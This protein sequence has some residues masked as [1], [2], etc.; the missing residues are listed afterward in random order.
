MEQKDPFPR[1]FATIQE[2]IVS[3]P[4]DNEQPVLIRLS[5]GTYQGPITIDKPYITL[6]G[7]SPE[8]TKITGS[9][10]AFE[11]LEDGIKRGTFRTQTVFID[12]HDFTAKNI[13]FE[14]AA[15]FGRLAGQA[16][17]LYVDGDHIVFDHCHLLASQD[18]LFAAPLPPKEVEPGGFRGPKEFAPR[19]VGR[20]YYKDCYIRGD[21]D[22]IFGGATAYF[23]NCEIF[24]QKTDDAP[25]AASMEEQKIYG[26]VT[27]AST[28]KES[29]YG[30]VFDHCKLTGNCPD[31][32]C[33]LGRPWREFAKVVYLHCEMGAHI[34]PEGWHDWGKTS[35]YDTIFFA[36]YDSTG[37]GANPEKRASFS[38]QLTDEEAA[39]YTIDHI[40]G[41]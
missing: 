31:N 2:A 29:P 16:L 37:P 41:S 14:N 7:D 20:H 9:L 17:A 36:E 5:P 35:A 15:G 32:S 10:G 28:P 33:Y 26:Y 19:I 11:I 18:T 39:E 22:F 34:R 24:S 3:V 21:V 23:E 30:F 40:L 25:A 4:S 6:M 8:N 1:E 13:T 27:A 12:T 38:H